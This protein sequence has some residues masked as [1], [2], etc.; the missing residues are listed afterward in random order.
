MRHLFNK[1]HIWAAK[2]HD[3]WTCNSHIRTVRLS[4]YS[5]AA[6]VRENESELGSQWVGL[7]AYQQ[8]QRLISQFNDV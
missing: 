2:Y 3:A 6:Y 5:S 8:A 1:R 7:A 4:L